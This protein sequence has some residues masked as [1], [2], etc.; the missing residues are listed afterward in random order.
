MDKLHRLASGEGDD[1]IEN[2]EGEHEVMGD[3][4]RATAL[5]AKEGLREG[6]S[7]GKELDMQK[8]F[9]A[10]YQRGIE[11]GLVIG[12]AKALVENRQTSYGKPPLPLS[13]LSLVE[14]A[15]TSDVDGTDE[16]GANVVRDELD[17]IESD[18][19]ILKEFISKKL[20]PDPGADCCGGGE[21]DEGDDSGDSCG[22]RENAN[23]TSLLTL[24]SSKG[25]IEKTDDCLEFALQLRNKIEQRIG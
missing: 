2:G 14:P 11:I 12:A 3:F 10:G 15:V 20:L 23:I 1:D 21:C 25:Q 19:K 17:V 16:S 7:H 22:N 18:L 8:G 13:K 6:L 4:T 5:V 24:D 9:N